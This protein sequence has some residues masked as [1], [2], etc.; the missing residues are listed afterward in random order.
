MPA[1]DEKTQE[2]YDALEKTRAELA[3]VSK[4]LDVTRSEVAAAQ[5]HAA[6]CTQQ[7]DVA[8]RAAAAA[9][10][11]QHEVADALQQKVPD[12]PIMSAGRF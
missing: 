7:Q 3:V 2:L 10:R 6:Q 9:V 1:Q 11:L 4:E 12:F 8:E 5:Q